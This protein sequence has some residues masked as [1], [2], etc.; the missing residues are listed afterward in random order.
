MSFRLRIT[1][2]MIA[3]I[4]VLFSIGGAA[5]IS[6][7]FNISI[8]K[9]E[10]EAVGN[11]RLTLRML[12]MV[13]EGQSWFNEE[14][15]TDTL[16]KI[17]DRSSFDA[18]RLLRAEAQTEEESAGENAG[19]GPVFTKGNTGDFPE[20][21]SAASAGGITVHYPA[22]RAARPRLFTT[23]TLSIGDDAYILQIASDLEAVY[24]VR[25]QQRTLFGRIYIALILLAA[26]LSYLTSTVV[27]R[28]LRKLSRASRE[29][30]SGNL[31]YRTNI[32]SEDEIGRLSRDFD[33]MA[34]NLEE[35]ISR[36]REEGERKEQFMGAFTHELKTPMTS[37]IGYADLLRSQALTPEEQAD[38]VDYIFSEGKRL[39]NMSL[40]LLDLFVADKNEI[41]LQTV[42]PKELIGDIAEHLKPVFD[43]AG[44]T[45]TAS[46]GEGKCALEPDLFR[47]LLI[48]LLDNARKAMPDGGRAF[49]GAKSEG[50]QWHFAVADTGRG[51]APEEVK[52]ITE[53]FYR[54]DKSRARQEG[55]AG[56][57][58]A[59]CEK[60]VT[61]HGGTMDF[62]SEPGKGTT[63]H[64]RIPA[65][66][67]TA[68]EE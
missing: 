65:K 31:S 37:I 12:E 58:L 20:P 14:E 46:C 68:D 9:E 40:K 39:E 29:I 41:V 26:G 5:L 63:V 13:G 2:S 18:V 22:A 19:Q 8:E 67:V 33:R 49:I 48:N 15:L 6:A 60:I 27:T 17:S 43:K 57:G 21:F 50:G 4:A 54:V 51:M 16:Q 42:S 23:S 62:E 7:S 3:V 47:T 45:I 56:L 25:A 44:I 35:N 61:L 64:V 11:T 1:L 32:G 38:A 10:E 30:A 59:L 36:I 66:E 52:H 28:S 53:A 34:E 55:S 24:R